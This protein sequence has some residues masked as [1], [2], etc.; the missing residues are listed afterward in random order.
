M[1]A[2]RR[3]VTCGGPVMIVAAAQISA[4]ELKNPAV[5]R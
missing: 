3:L 4:L 1:V 2:P 5:A